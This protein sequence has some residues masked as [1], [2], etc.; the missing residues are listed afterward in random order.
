MRISHCL[1]IVVPVALLWSAGAVAQTHH[2]FW[3]YQCTIPEMHVIKVGDQP[4]HALGVEQFN[5]SSFQLETDKSKASVS[6]LT[7]DAW[8]P[9]GHDSGWNTINME[10][11]DRVSL[12]T[13][14]CSP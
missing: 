14:A 10:N 6:T 8:G 2:F 11:G 7:F 5:C 12:H 1:I 3:T 4:G 13:T 9:K